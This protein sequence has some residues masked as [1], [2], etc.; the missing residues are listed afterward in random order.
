MVSKRRAAVEGD[1]VSVEREAPFSLPF[2]LTREIEERDNVAEL[3]EAFDDGTEKDVVLEDHGA[4]GR[5]V[6]YCGVGRCCHSERI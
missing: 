5:L 1:L 6:R 2:N 4:E 3:G